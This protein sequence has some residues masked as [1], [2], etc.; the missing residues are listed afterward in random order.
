[1]GG[2]E[3]PRVRGSVGRRVSGGLDRSHWS[4]CLLSEIRLW[5]L[6][7]ICGVKHVNAADVSLWNDWR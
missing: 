3:G 6:Y 5:C 1:M 7:K 2:S 4:D